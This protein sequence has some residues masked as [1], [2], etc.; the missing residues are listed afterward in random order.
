MA[1]ITGAVLTKLGRVPTTYKN[2]IAAGHY[3]GVAWMYREYVT[4]ARPGAC[5]CF[6]TE[7]VC[8]R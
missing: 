8:R 6:N 4:G 5:V 7:P 2:L 1:E 3:S